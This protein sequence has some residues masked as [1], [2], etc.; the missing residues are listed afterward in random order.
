MKLLKLLVQLL[1]RL[2]DGLRDMYGVSNK[3]LGK[4]K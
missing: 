1:D 4:K 2:D 3:N